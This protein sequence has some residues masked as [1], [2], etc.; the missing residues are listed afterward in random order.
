IEDHQ[1]AVRLQ[2]ERR[3][4]IERCEGEVRELRTTAEVTATRIDQHEK[5]AERLRQEQQEEM[6]WGDREGSDGFAMVERKL[7]GEELQQLI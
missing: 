1:L 4:A 5:E 3:E 2:R 6:D 7:T